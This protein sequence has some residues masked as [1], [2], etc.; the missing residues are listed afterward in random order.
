MRV[1]ASPV[2]GR[3]GGGGRWLRL[4]EVREAA[5]HDN[6]PTQMYWSQEIAKQTPATCDLKP[7]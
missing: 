6:L 7:A 3:K 1:R 4:T 2:E 5:E